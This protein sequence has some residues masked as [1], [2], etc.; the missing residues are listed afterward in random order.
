[1]SFHRF[2]L[3]SSQRLIL[4]IHIS[5]NKRTQLLSKRIL[6]MTVVEL[7][8]YGVLILIV[9]NVKT[10]NEIGIITIDIIM[11]NMW[12][13]ERIHRIHTF[14]PCSSIKK[15]EKNRNQKQTNEIIIYDLFKARI[16]LFGHSAVKHQDNESSI[17]LLSFGFKFYK[18]SSF[19]FYQ[20]IQVIETIEIKK[21]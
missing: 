19:H 11:L 14:F 21:I 16:K 8:G 17:W 20:F 5:V 18:F 13:N 10:R 12:I 1:M 3:S 9:N 15:K 6:N 4:I 2:F 7:I